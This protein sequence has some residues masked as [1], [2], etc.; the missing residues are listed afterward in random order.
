MEYIPR[1]TAQYSGLGYG[2][3]QWLHSDDAPAWTPLARPISESRLG[4]IATGGVYASGQTAFHY[5][6]D[7]SYRSIPDRKSVV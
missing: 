5:K 6:D 3:Y 7:T 2:E 4:I 1:I